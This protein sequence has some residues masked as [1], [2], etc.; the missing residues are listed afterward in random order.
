MNDFENI[1]SELGSK[2]GKKGV[3]SLVESNYATKVYPRSGHYTFRFFRENDGRYYREVMLHHIDKDRIYQCNDDYCSVCKV[4]EAS[5]DMI[6]GKWNHLPRYRRKPWYIVKA[7]FYEVPE[8][9]KKFFPLNKVVGFRLSQAEFADLS[10][11]MAGVPEKVGRAMTDLAVDAPAVTL[12]KVRAN[13]WKKVKEGQE[14]SI[15]DK[16]Y[17]K[18]KG[19][20]RNID[21]LYIPKYE[22]PSVD[23]VRDLAYKIGGE[24]LLGSVGDIELVSDIVGDEGTVLSRESMLS[25]VE[26]RQE[27]E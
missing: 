6:S 21:T 3:G 12:E 8:R 5:I 9:S 1:V 26:G 15:T 7:V 16:N 14:F 17:S 23:Q 2:K 20:D 27:D 11:L 13:N 24:E 18:L 10:M 4:L 25:I 19:I 22:N